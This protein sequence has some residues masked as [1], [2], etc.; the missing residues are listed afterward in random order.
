MAPVVYS[1]VKELLESSF[2]GNS[3]F[4][5]RMEDT[6]EMYGAIKESVEVYQSA[7]AKRQREL[8]YVTCHAALGGGGGLGWG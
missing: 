6:P 8:L 1:Q 4:R 5:S 3:Q 2:G 7:E